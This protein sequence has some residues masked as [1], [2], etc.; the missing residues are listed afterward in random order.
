M[1]AEF[2]RFSSVYDQLLHDPIRERFAPGSSFFHERKW[3]L[4][5]D[6]L[7]QTGI[8]LTQI[9]W[10]DVGCGRGELL[11]IGRPYVGR[12]IGCDVSAGMLDGSDDVEVVHQP[13]PDR[14]PF[15]DGRLDLVT[16]VCVYH[17]VPLAD[18]PRL[19][20]EVFRVLRPGGWFCIIEHNPFNPVTQLIVSRTPVD[21]D[22]RLLTARRASRT[23]R[24]AGFH[25]IR[26]RFFLF[27]PEGLF[28][29]MGRFE[30]LLSGVPLGGQY[31]VMGRKP[32]S[33]SPMPL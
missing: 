20:S 9:T 16:A 12:A 29:K 1:A 10:L 21:A 31:G 6:W 17:H 11:R 15:A 14:L 18:R 26:N 2:D 3:V 24:E 25:P 32:S 8:D 23:L 27:L 28:R 19:S 30:S 22:A 5:R 33:G 7:R 4:L 13:A